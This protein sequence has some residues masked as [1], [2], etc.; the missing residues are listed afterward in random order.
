MEKDHMVAALTVGALM[1]ADHM[2]VDSTRVDPTR[3]APMVAG[4]TA[5]AVLAK[6]VDVILAAARDSTRAAILTAVAADTLPEAILGVAHQ[7][8]VRRG[9]V[10][11]P[12]QLPAS[13]IRRGHLRRGHS[14]LKGP[15]SAE[16]NGIHLEIAG[17]HLPTLH[18]EIR[19]S[20]AAASGTHLKIVGIRL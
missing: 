20:L 13:I 3:A 19:I 9:A 7:L 2:V 15:P 10:A 4:L 18:V 1:A 17:I 8:D 11:R 12:Q 14:E 6:E 16:A 5:L